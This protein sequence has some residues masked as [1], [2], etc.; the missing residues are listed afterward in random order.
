MTRAI[1]LSLLTF[2]LWTSTAVQG[3]TFVRFRTVFGD[4][5]VELLDQERPI[6]VKNFLQYVR[7]GA[8]AGMFFHRMVPNFVIQ[9]GGFVNTAPG[10]TNSR[11]GD[12]PVR[13]S[14]TNEFGIGP[15][16]SNVAG[17]IAMAKTS[18]PNSATSQFFFNLADNS[19][20]LDSTNNSGG[21]TVFGRVVG[22]TNTL[23]LF[24]S[25]IANR[26]PATNVIVNANSPTGGPFGEL[27][28]LRF[29][30]AADDI[31][32]LLVYVDVSLMNV[33]VARQADGARKI[34]WDSALNA[35]NVVEFTS[36]FPPVWTTLTNVVRPTATNSVVV[37][38]SGDLRR[39][40]RVRTAY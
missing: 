8:Y 29:P 22:G 23:A 19:S 24:N 2:C 9:G 33:Q 39:F 21:F 10:T 18:D 4:T 34:T 1:L 13:A 17:T 28:V 38:S 37:D 6:T 30:G 40:Y 11:V 27:P 32:T 15:L 31:F 12:V 16:I 35:T 26:T 3:G 25:F 14:I 5:E 36:V 7:D 20:S